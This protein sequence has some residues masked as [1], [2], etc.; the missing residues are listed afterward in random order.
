M[1]VRQSTAEVLEVFRRHV[2]SRGT[3]VDSERRADDARSLQCS[4]LLDAQALDLRFDHLAKILGHS[5][6]YLLQRQPRLPS[7]TLPRDQASLSQMLQRSH[8]EQWIAA[9]VTMHELG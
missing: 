9:R 7:A 3:D 2:S 1:P 5:D 4:P 6:H 8:H